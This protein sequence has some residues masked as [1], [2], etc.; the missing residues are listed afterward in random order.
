MPART[1]RRTHPT[2][3]KKVCQSCFGS[4]AAPGGTMTYSSQ[5]IAIEYT[6]KFR[7]YDI[8]DTPRGRGRVSALYPDLPYYE[9]RTVQVNFGS[10]PDAEGRYLDDDDIERFSDADL[11]LVDRIEGLGSL[12]VQW[13]HLGGGIWSSVASG[14]SLTVVPLPTGEFRWSANDMAESVHEMTSL[15][16]VSANLDQAKAAAE[17]AATGGTKTGARHLA[18]DSGDGADLSHCPF[19]GSGSIIGGHDGTVSCEFCGKNFTVQVQPEFK[20]MPQTVNGQPYNIPGMPGGGPDAGAAGEVESDAAEQSQQ[21]APVSEDD[22]HPHF[23][24][25]GL[26]KDPQPEDKKPNPFAATSML[27]T[28]DGTALPTRSYLQ[29]LA[30]AHAEDRNAVL[31]QVRAENA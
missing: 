31:A 19:C 5:H 14:W 24:S 9:G 30:L 20:G 12:H 6:G 4:P 1:H 3:G 17:Q 21:G 13:S 27:V 26:P 8:V 16:G 18:H 29:H 25:E 2:T 28:D 7:I 11:T 15:G 23:D 22:G 10:Q